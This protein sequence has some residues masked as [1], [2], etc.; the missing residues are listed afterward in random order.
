LKNFILGISYRGEGPTPFCAG[1]RLNPSCW[2]SFFVLPS[3]CAVREGESISGVSLHPPSRHDA[4]KLQEPNSH[5]NPFTA[6]RCGQ[7]KS[8]PFCNPLD[9][10]SLKGRKQ[11]GKHRAETWPPGESQCHNVAWD[12][13]SCKP[14]FRQLVAKDHLTQFGL[15]LPTANGAK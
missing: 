12:L 10:Y 3:V 11:G 14:T 1:E 2:S 5:L 8:G 9:R 15:T 13:R 6:A 7:N 4:D